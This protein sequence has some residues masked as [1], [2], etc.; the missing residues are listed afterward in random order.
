M[1]AAIPIEVSARHIHLCQKDVDVL[2][3]AGFL[4]TKMKDLSQPGQFA[5][6]EQVDIVGPK[7]SID[8]VRVLGPARPE[9]QVEISTTDARKLGI[10]PSFRHSG[11]TK[12][13]AGLTLRGPK[14][15]VKLDRG[16]IVALRHLHCDVPNAEKLGI[17]DKDIV[18]IRIGGARAVT[19]ENVLVRVNK[20]FALALHVDTDE[21]NAAGLDAGVTGELLKPTLK[22]MGAQA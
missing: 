10:A 1:S 17:K 16:A 2:F 19:L 20:D 7:G 8:K 11:D 13:T 18:S 3:G 21:G 4:L 9:S 22:A 15:E 12:G 5:C 6:G 14:G